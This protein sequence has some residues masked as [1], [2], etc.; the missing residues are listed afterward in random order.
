MM[1]NYIGL[2][3]TIQS[4]KLLAR[5]DAEQSKAKGSYYTGHD[6]ATQTTQAPLVRVMATK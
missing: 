2:I 3:K 4:H 1:W 5:G 6:N